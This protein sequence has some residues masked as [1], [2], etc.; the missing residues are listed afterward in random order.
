MAEKPKHITW[1]Q[2]IDDAAK[3]RSINLPPFIRKPM[4]LA[5]T[6]PAGDGRFITVRYRLVPKAEAE[7]DGIQWAL[8]QE[9]NDSLDLAFRQPPIPEKDAVVSILTILKGWI[10]DNWSIERA[11]DSIHQAVLRQNG[12]KLINE[13]NQICFSDVPGFN[14]CWAGS[15]PYQSGY[16]FGSEDGRLL[17]TDENAKELNPP[18]DGSSTASPINGFASCGD[19]FAVSTPNDFCMW[20]LL[21]DSSKIDRAAIPTQCQSLSV[22]KDGVFLVPLATSGIMLVNSRT[23]IRKTLVMGHDANDYLSCSRVAV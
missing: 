21:T 9:G 13:H 22:T 10:L 3:E 17:F 6:E 1:L 11:R 12:D 19:F 16:C 15:H 2:A 7:R 23:D 4:G 5:V 20:H 8:R 18:C 14:V